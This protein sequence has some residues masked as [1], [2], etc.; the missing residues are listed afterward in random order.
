[1]SVA[2]DISDDDE[3]DAFACPQL[4]AKEQK[5]GG[6]AASSPTTIDG[7]AVAEGRDRGQKRDAAEMA[8]AG[9]EQDTDK[10]KARG[11]AKDRAKAK[12]EGRAAK[13]YIALA[14][15]KAKRKSSMKQCNTCQKAKPLDAFNWDSAKCHGCKFVMDNIYYIAKTQGK[16]QWLSEQN[17]DNQKKQAL[18]DNY[19][20]AQSL[21]ASGDSPKKWSLCEYIV[22][23]Q[24]AQ[25]LEVVD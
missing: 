9:G 8:A 25:S 3:E 22:E 2:R 6:A 12:A 19:A 23:L 7:S 10:G 11:K 16:L 14:V 24:S 20:D 5:V 18:V 13:K 21:Y 4:A 17:Q 15:R 1:M